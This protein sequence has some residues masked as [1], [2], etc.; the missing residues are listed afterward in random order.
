VKSEL[1]ERASSLDKVR[2]GLGDLLLIGNFVDIEFFRLWH[3]LIDR[4]GSFLDLIDVGLELV[5]NTSFCL[6]NWLCLC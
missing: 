3:F 1:Q 6:N 4:V 2:D 5:D